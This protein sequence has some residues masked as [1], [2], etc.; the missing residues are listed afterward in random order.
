MST[1]S[2]G[3][4]ASMSIDGTVIALLNGVTFACNATVEEW[5]NMGET[6]TSDVLHGVR[7]YSGGFT[8]AYVDNTYLDYFLGGSAL[9]GTVFPRGGATPYI[10]GTIEITGWTLGGMERGAAT[11]VIE[12]GT[13]VMISVSKS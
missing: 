4:L 6:V 12:E 1:P 8:K 9:I 13:F 10:S 3:L 7:T 2:E 11:P 5:A